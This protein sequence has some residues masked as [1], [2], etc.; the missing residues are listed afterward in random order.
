MQSPSTVSLLPAASHITGYLFL[1][2][3][4]KVYNTGIPSYLNACISLVRL[5]DK[6][7]NS[8]CSLFRNRDRYPL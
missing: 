4:V 3:Y 2:Y 7:I 6:I 5:K 8:H 1:S